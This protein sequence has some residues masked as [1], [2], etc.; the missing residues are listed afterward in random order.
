MPKLRSP[1]DERLAALPILLDHEVRVR[2]GRAPGGRDHALRRGHSMSPAIP[3][4]AALRLQL[5]AIGG[6]EP[7]SSYLE[8]RVFRPDMTPASDLRSFVGVRELERAAA[9]VVELAATHHVYVGCAPR[10]APGGTKDLVARRVVSLGR[11]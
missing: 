2:S 3:Q 1:V 6:N 10:I 7:S 5:A 8:L 9:R 4:D 11:P